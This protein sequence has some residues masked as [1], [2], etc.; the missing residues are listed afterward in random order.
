MTCFEVASLV[1]GRKWVRNPHACWL[2]MVHCGKKERVC[3][4][5]KEGEDPFVYMYETVLSDLGFTLPFDFFEADVLR[6]LGIAPSQ[7]H[8]NSWAAIQAFKVVCLALGILPSALSL[9]QTSRLVDTL[10]VTSVF[11]F[12]HRLLQG[13]RR[14]RLDA[15]VLTLGL[16]HCIGGSPQVQGASEESTAKVDLQLL[17]S[18]PR[19]M[20]CKDRVSCASTNNATFRLKSEFLYVV[21]F[22]KLGLAPNVLIH[23]VFGLQKQGVDMAELIRKARLTNKAKS[24]DR[25]ASDAGMTTVAAER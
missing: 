23:Y 10:G 12:L 9:H 19:G 4:S 8:P 25:K 11:Y 13:S 24:A 22:F 1:E 6:M 20:N 16:C 17:D 21:T 2:T 5:V 15:F 7:L 18:L 14:L 3:H